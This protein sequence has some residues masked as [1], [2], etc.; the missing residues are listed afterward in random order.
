[1]NIIEDL[2][3]RTHYTDQEWYLAN[4][5]VIALR[6][7]IRNEVKL[8]DSQTLEDAFHYALLLE[9]HKKAIFISKM[10]GQTSFYHHPHLNFKGILLGLIPPNV[11]LSHTRPSLKLPFKM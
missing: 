11:M 1:M 7:Y 3:D 10:K 4:R 9:N 5:F 2:I 8:H 6:G